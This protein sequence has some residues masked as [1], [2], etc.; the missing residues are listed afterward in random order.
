MIWNTPVSKGPAWWQWG[1]RR[2][3]VLLERDEVRVG[4]DGGD[5]PLSD[6]EVLGAPGEPPEETER[7]VLTSSM[8]VRWT[9]RTA[10]RAVVV[11]PASPITVLGD[12]TAEIFVSTPLWIGLR[13]GGSGEPFFE[14]PSF[15]PSNTWFGETP[16]A[17]ELA[18]STRSRARARLDQLTFLPGRA[19]TRVTLVNA[20]P[21][22]W[23][24]DRLKVPVNHL[25]LFHTERSGVWTAGVRIEC[26]DADEVDVVVDPSTPKSVG[27]ASRFQDP[28]NSATPRL[29]LR[30]LGSLG[31]S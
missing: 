30:A 28:R 18:Y 24:V 29:V 17:G 9:A 6:V 3:F 27:P 5:E 19:V 20:Q 8:D 25:P 10:D 26:K 2:V 11:R 21:T 31:L 4:V 1:S 12:A 13:N 23:H 7:F 16:Q 15:R 14:V 22:P